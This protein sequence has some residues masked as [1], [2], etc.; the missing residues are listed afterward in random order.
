[1]LALTVVPVAGI[2]PARLLCRG[3]L[4]PLCLPF[5]HTGG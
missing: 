1:M 5:H 3:I 2:E 4:S